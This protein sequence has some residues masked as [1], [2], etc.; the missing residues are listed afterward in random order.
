MS[1]LFVTAGSKA[2][3]GGAA[4]SFTGTD[5]IASDFA[6]VSWTEIKG[7]TNIGSFGDT[8]TLVTSE[9]VGEQRTRKGKGTR[10]AGSMTII[11]DIDY[12]DAGQLAVIA[13]EKTR[14]TYPVKVVFNDAPSG[15][16]P[17]ERYFV[18]LVMSAAEALNEANNAMALNMVLEIDSNIVRVA[19]AA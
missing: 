9:R 4:K 8:A 13:A 17:S 3:F 16:T 1:N 10:N 5:F 11:A 19:A 7:I 15:G 18:G 6:A 2:Y 12:A 14:D